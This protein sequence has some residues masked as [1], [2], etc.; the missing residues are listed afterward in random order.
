MHL[1][2]WTSETRALLRDPAQIRGPRVRASQPGIYTV[3]HVIKANAAR[4]RSVARMLRHMNQ[5]RLIQGDA[6]RAI[7]LKADFSQRDE[8]QTRA[9]MAAAKERARQTLPNWLRNELASKEAADDVK[10]RYKAHL[11][12][13]AREYQHEREAAQEAH[14]QLAEHDRSALEALH[15]QAQAVQ[16]HDQDDRSDEEAD[17]EIDWACM[18][19]RLSICPSFPL[20]E[21]EE[22]LNFARLSIWTRLEELDV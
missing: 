3:A 7:P 20:H 10:R 17:V 15:R 12:A 18:P 4:R 11:S 5:G 9:E 6:L 19:L 16:L 21:H 22:P 13:D 8:A 1:S 14:R 2:L